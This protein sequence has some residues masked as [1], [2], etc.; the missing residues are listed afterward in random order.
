MH[1]GV[2]KKKKNDVQENLGF[3]EDR[4]IICCF[5]FENV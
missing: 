3:N 4:I 5:F 2:Q 1:T